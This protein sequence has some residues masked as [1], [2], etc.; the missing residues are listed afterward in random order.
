MVNCTPKMLR[1]HKEVQDVL[2]RDIMQSTLITFSED[3][4]VIEASRMLVK[5]CCIMENP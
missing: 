2:V 4:D 1:I 3:M 5:H